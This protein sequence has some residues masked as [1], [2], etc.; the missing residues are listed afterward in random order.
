MAAP[1]I[2]TVVL[3]RF[4]FSDLSR[5]AIEKILHKSLPKIPQ[6]YIIRQETS[7]R[8]TEVEQLSKWGRIAYPVPA[9]GCLAI[10]SVR[11]VSFGDG[12][13]SSRNT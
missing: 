8:G 3:V 6:R 4:P 10:L 9:S 11:A 12:C 1:A 7:V 13:T 2:G 5:L